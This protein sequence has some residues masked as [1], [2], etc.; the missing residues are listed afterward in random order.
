MAKYRKSSNRK[1]VLFFIISAILVVVITNIIPKI[2]VYIKTPEAA[3]LLIF[4]RDHNSHPNYNAEWWYLNLLV[5]TE[6]I[7]GT[8]IKDLGYL[9]S[10][11]RIANKSGLLN[12]RFDQS[13]KSFSEKT[14]VG[15]M[16]TVSLIDSKYL[17]VDYINGSNYATLEEKPLGADG[18]RK[19]KLIGKTDQIGSFNLTL[20]ERTLSKSPLLWGETT[21]MVEP[22]GTTGDCTGQISVFAPNDTFYYS[23]PD[24]DITGTITD[25]DGIK[26]NV[27]IGKAWIDHQWFNTRPPADWKGHYWTGFHF[28]ESKDLYSPEPHHAVGFVTQIYNTG[29]KYTYWVKR[30]ANG[31]NECGTEG[32]I[33]INNYG[34]TNYP[35]SWNISLTKSS[36][37]FIKVNG[38]PFSNN[39]IFDPP[40]GPNFFEPASYF[41]G[42]LNGKSVTGLGFFETHLT[43]PL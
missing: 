40:I 30:N 37:T 9:L 2:Q 11:S 36:N 4:P 20:K 6:K 31:T 17:F 5:R 38:L 19:Y 1:G 3:S 16:L 12:S 23:I 10:F 43:K 8:N 35:S 24:L 41:K 28:T 25:V 34:A 7:D 27:K 29:P 33:T 18:K 39:Q 15:G 22:G 21:G 13:T 32:N 42:Y 26:R 14:D